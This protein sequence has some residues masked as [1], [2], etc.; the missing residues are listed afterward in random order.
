MTPDPPTFAQMMAVADDLATVDRLADAFGRL[1]S[2]ERQLIVCALAGNHP[3]NLRARR[4]P[5]LRGL[6][7]AGGRLTADL[8]REAR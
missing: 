4:I 1:S 3:E 7:K 2:P 5:V 6:A 8:R